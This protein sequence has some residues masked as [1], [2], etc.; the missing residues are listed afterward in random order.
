MQ[1]SVVLFD[2]V[3]NLCSGAVRFI[4]ERDP[5][6]IFR[7]A[8]LQSDVGRQLLRDHGVEPAEGDPDTIVLI[9]HGRP[10]E[11]STAALHIARRLGGPYRLIF[12]IG[13][14]MPRFLRDLVYDFVARHRYRWF[15][16]RDAC[17][18]PTPELRARFL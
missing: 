5:E 3:C 12:L 11:R 14:L 18:V 2:G 8:S 6:G 16:K 10:F 17:M 13:S 7:F 9:D 4:A 1:H 15:G